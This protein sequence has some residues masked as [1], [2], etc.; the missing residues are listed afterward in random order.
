LT[1]GKIP[2]THKSLICGANGLS[3][4]ENTETQTEQQAENNTDIATEATAEVNNNESEPSVASSETND[5]P[6]NNAPKETLLLGDFG[7][8]IWN[9]EVIAKVTTGNPHLVPKFEITREEL[10]RDETRDVVTER[11]SNWLED[12]LHTDL[13]PLFRLKSAIEHIATEPEAQAEA[14][15]TETPA[16]ETATDAETAPTAIE[17][18]AAKAPATHT[19]LSEEA[20]VLA[21]KLLDAH[22]IL[23]R[24]YVE[25]EVSA[26]SQDVRKSL[27][28]LGIRFGRSAV[29]FPLLLKPKAVRLNAILGYLSDGAKAEKPFLPPVG[30]TSFEADDTRTEKEYDLIGFRNIAGRSIR[31][32]I[33]DRVLDVLYEAQKEAKGPVAMPQSVVSFLGVSNEI[34]E[35]V[36]EALGWVKN[37]DD[38]GKVLW[39]FRRP[40][41]PQRNFK[42]RPQTTGSEGGNRENYKRPDQNFGG[43]KRKDVKGGKPKQSRD[44]SSGPKRVD[45]DSPFAILANLKLGDK[46]E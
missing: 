27:R 36:I 42:P 33:L 2:L 6:A 46:K 12:M 16:T 43:K 20:K 25:K 39:Q 5:A 34:A 7:E 18:P 11:L 14:E 45:G 4:E 44:Y 26:L 32:D 22:G 41:P 30:V 24:A 29:Y 17:T 19:V 31:I 15:V 1:C 35:K 37:T 38:E 13:F 21:Q 10:N 8:I 23:N 3:E 40:K 28:V 9:D